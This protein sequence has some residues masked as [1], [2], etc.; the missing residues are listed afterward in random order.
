MNLYFSNS[1]TQATRVRI[2]VLRAIAK[3]LTTT[4]EAAFVQ[5]FIPRPVLRYVS[6]EGVTNPASGTGRSYTFVDAVSRF[7]DLVTDSDLSSAYKRAG[8]TFKG[9]MEQYFVLLRETEDLPIATTSNRVPLGLR[10]GRGGFPRGLVRG[11]RGSKRRGG[12]PPGTPFKKRLI[13]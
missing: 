7:G 4:T 3:R 2:E 13:P 5:S 6:E 10:G 9:A 12:T 8:G 1:V 11:G